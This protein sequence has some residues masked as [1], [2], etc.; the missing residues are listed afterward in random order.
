MNKLNETFKINPLYESDG[1]KIGHPLMLAPGTVREYWTWIP[2]STKHMPQGIDKI[3]SAGQQLVVRYIHSAFQEQFFNKNIVV[4]QE[5]T[6]DMA[7]Y[8]MTPYNFKGF[9]DLHKLGYLPILI[10]SLPEGVHTNPNIPHMCGINTVD[11]YAWLGL[12]LE[13]LISKIAWQLPVA[14]TIGAKF[15]EN[16][17]EWV[18]KTN[19]KDLWLADFMNHDF[20]SRGGNP[21]TSIAVGL[22]H[23]MS[24]SG[25]DT[26]NVIPA[27][28]YYYDFPE[29][30]VA[31]YSVNASEHSVTCTQIF[32]Y[33][34]ILE[35][36][37]P[38][39][40]QMIEHYYM[41]DVPCEGSV[42]FPDYL[43]IA[44][45][46][47]LKDWLG[48]FPTGILSYVCDTFDTF[49]FATQIIPR[50]KDF[51]LAREGKLVLRPDTGDPVDIICGTSHCENLID[52]VVE[53]FK[54][55]GAK[56]VNERNT[57]SPE[58]K[59][60]VE[61]LWDIFGGTVSDEG[62]KVLDSHI[63]A[64]Y[65][66]S[67]NLERQIAMYTRLA[68]KQFAATNIVLGIGSFTYVMQTRDSAGYAAKGAWF[69]TEEFLAA[70]DGSGFTR[71]QFDI[72]KDPKTGDGSKKSLKGFQ[73]V[74]P[75]Y[76]VESQVTEEKAFSEDNMLK[77]IYKDGKF[78]NQTTLTEIRERLK[79]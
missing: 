20:H 31:V 78:F 41:Y 16:S 45:W 51:I 22:G 8:L 2:R 13:T 43:A 35:S 44:E 55:F 59:G 29:D 79:S 24:N 67:I 15:K 60:V 12:F 65:G 38:E 52:E 71:K 64:I 73:F 49:K 7:A 42:N 30:Q 28:R 56:R 57:N 19:S 68:A 46:L 11:G 33:K 23:A 54:Q 72:Y 69:E 4:A 75:D 58:E 37:S 3:M 10:Q 17:V 21:F 5:F 27:A 62:Y 9:E 6:R 74:N 70:G 77:T 50:A 61:I 32:Y 39:A 63:G 36:G 34:D 40:K 66:D 25:S 18:K 48:R 76:T 47:N 14:A 26:L 1:Y 53:G